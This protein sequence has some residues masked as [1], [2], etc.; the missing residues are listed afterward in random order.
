MN[1]RNAV[2][3]DLAAINE[4]ENA[5]FP[6]NEAAGLHRISNRLDVF[7]QHFWL[8]E[9]HGQILGFINGMVT[10]N[11]R[12]IDEMFNNTGLHNENEKWQAVFGLAVSPEYQK[13]GYAGKLIHHLIAKSK[14]QNR[15]GI[16]LTCKD[17]LISYYQKFGFEDLGI[18]A[19]VHGGEVWHDMLITF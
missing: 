10:S 17:Y 2:I 3:A 5:C 15:A 13:K 16:T 6:P 18:S 14:E 19:S 4:I 11:K 9:D 8:L 1:F 7:P 12:L